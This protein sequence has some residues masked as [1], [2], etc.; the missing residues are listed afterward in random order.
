MVYETKTGSHRQ[1]VISQ[2]STLGRGGALRA[3]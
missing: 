3:R 2:Y 1:A